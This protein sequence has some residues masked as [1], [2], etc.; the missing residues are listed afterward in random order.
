MLLKQLLAGRKRSDFVIIKDNVDFNGLAILKSFIEEG[1]GRNV[2]IHLILSEYEL[3]NFD[4]SQNIVIHKYFPDP[5]RLLSIN[6]DQKN[7][8]LMV[9]KILNQSKLL[10]A[11]VLILIDSIASI[12]NYVDIHVLCNCI[13]KLTTSNNKD[14]PVAQVVTILHSELIPE[15]SKEFKHLNYIATTQINLILD[16]DRR[17]MLDVTYR[18]LNGKVQKEISCCNYNTNKELQYEIRKDPPKNK[19]PESDGIL[20]KTTFKLTLEEKEKESRSQVVLPYTKT[21]ITSVKGRIFYEPDANDDW[22]DED[23]DDDLEI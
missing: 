4:L 23:P 10:G 22:D 9:D 12:L 20:V 1:K 13:R 16:H 15:D 19:K 11:P 8:E 17:P 3:T 5:W 7:F 2:P 6:D 18:H 14:I 21:S